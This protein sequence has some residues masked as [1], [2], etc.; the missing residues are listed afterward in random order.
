M[1]ISKRVWLQE[2]PN[3]G[4]SLFYYIRVLPYDRR[5]TLPCKSWATG[6]SFDVKIF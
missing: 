6:L 5:L 4:E 2:F 1:A 3:I